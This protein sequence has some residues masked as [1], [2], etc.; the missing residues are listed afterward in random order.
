MS[1]NPN[2]DDWDKLILLLKYLNTTQHDKLVLYI[3][4]I[5]IIKW[6]RDTA[7]DIHL[8]FRITQEV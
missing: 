6:Y 3:D 2:Q 5:H 8:D 7:F 4:D 1:K